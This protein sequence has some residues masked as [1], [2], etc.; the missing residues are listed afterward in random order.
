VFGEPV[1][2]PDVIELYL[3]GR[4]E[5]HRVVV[6]WRKGTEMG[7]DFEHVV[8][9]DDHDVAAPGADLF[10]RLLKLESELGVLKRT[11]SELRAEMRATRS[12]T[13]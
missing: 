12:E 3:P 2:I 10:G 11:V 7:V 5:L 4:E 9:S 13:V 8:P 6:Q 1:A